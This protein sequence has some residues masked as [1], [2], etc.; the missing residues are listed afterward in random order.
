M[1]HVELYCLSY[2]ACLILTLGSQPPP[3]QRASRHS[4]TRHN[5]P[6][7]L[8]A[9]ITC[10]YRMYGLMLPAT[11]YPSG[12]T[13][14]QPCC[15]TR[16]KAVPASRCPPGTLLPAPRRGPEPSLGRYERWLGHWR[17]EYDAMDDCAIMMQVGAPKTYR[18]VRSRSSQV[19]GER[20]RA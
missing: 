14:P 8:D 18:V 10:E 2:A 4:Q 7:L 6:H 11:C 13:V 15:L 16:Y 5:Q 12:P 19:C 20:G 1:L 9:F 3:A 17:Q